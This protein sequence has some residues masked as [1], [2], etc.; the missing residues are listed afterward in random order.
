MGADL[1]A[2]GTAL[3]GFEPDADVAI[4]WS[5]DSR[6][7]LEFFPPL[8]TADGQPDRASYQHVVDAFH[9][10][11]IDAGAQSRILHVSQ[12]QALGPEEL[13]ARFPVLVAPALYVASDADLDLLRDYAA[14]GGHLIVGIRTG[15]GD[16]EARARTEVAPARLHEAA[17][18]R[19]EEFSNLRHDVPVRGSGPLAASDDAAARRWADGLVVTGAE[20][21]ARYDHPR[22]GDFPAITTNAHGA[23]RITVV[24]TVPSPA[25]AADLVRWAVPSPIA[26]GLASGRALPVTVASGALPDGRRAWF[27][28]NWGWAPQSL[29]LAASVTDPVT[30][31]QLQTGTDVSLPAWSTRTF[32]GE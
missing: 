15:Y 25:L 13:A 16:E 10:G 12:A 29:A 4:L 23:G 30:G 21:L 9:R 17:G 27:V 19:Y 24:G 31:D 3:D 7:A 32:I 5:N 8:A 26:D 1:Q 2:I 20:T 14:A 11:V 18:V 28:F 6:F 22:F